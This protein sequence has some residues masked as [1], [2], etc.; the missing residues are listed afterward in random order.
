MNDAR[1]ALAEAFDAETDPLRTFA[2]TFEAT[3]VDPFEPFLTDV[4]AARD[5]AERTIKGHERVW[6]QWQSHMGEERRHPACPNAD[7]VRRFARNELDEKENAPRTVAEKI[8]K[9]NE[10]Y[11]YWQADPVFPHSEGYNPFDLAR[12]TVDLTYDERTEPPHLSVTDLRETLQTVER[13]RDYAII[14]SQLKLGLRA[15]EVCN[16]Q[17]QD[18]ALDDDEL[19]THYASLG[20]HDRLDGRSNAVYIPHTREGNK[21]R[22]P[23]ML[24][25]NDELQDALAAYLR[26]R[27]DTGS[28][29]VFL[30]QNQ[31]AQLQKKA[32]NRFWKA[33]FHPEYAETEDHRAVTSHYGRHRFTT[34]WRVEQDLNRELVKYMRGD[35]PGSADID[36]RG[37]VDEYIHTYYEDIEVVYREEIYELTGS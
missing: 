3:G 16:L 21:S 31:H 4:L 35:T 12:A 29:Y 9:L 11:R 14:L 6:R 19:T 2:E 17:L 32:I 7:H 24:P 13:V 20:S 15:T 25:L 8:R 28:P 10:L 22:R 30:S 5:L 33:A 23:R 1:D 18:V 26:I 37:A 27:P 36:E 34:Y